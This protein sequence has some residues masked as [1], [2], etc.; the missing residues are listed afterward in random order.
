MS[1]GW[2]CIPQCE[3]DGEWGDGS[4]PGTPSTCRGGGMGA[5]SLAHPLRWE[6]IF[7]V[8][9]DGKVLPGHQQPSRGGPGTV[10]PLGISRQEPG[11]RKAK[12]LA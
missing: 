10:L 1:C 12:K 2:G 7:A 8:G 4:L 3:V 5:G 9:R 11:L 6:S